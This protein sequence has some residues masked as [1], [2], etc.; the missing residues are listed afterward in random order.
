MLP[1]ISKT[2]CRD[3]LAGNIQ[4]HKTFQKANGMKFQDIRR[5]LLFRLLYIDKCLGAGESHVAVELT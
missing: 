5:A 4:I 2:R 1:L 3:V